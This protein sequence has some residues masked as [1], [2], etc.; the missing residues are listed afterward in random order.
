MLAEKHAEAPL[1]VLVWHYFTY[2]YQLLS[3]GP[4]SKP[5]L[6]FHWR[7]HPVQYPHL[8]PQLWM[9]VFKLCNFVALGQALAH[10]A[11]IP[12][13]GVSDAK[14]V[15]VLQAASMD[16]HTY[17]SKDDNT[18]LAVRV[19][20]TATNTGTSASV[21]LTLPEKPACPPKKYPTR[22]LLEHR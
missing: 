14:T 2:L 3:C 12:F 6:V 21:Q 16:F 15:L 8:R 20:L 1:A 9:A 19:T 13:R 17:D 7:S 22:I 5:S 4:T 18:L 10:S 11:Y